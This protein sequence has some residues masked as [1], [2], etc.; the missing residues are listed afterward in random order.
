[1]P[2]TPVLC[3]VVAVSQ[4]LLVVVPEPLTKPDVPVPFTYPALNEFT[5]PTP[6]L[7]YP[8]NPAVLPLLLITDAKL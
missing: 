6:L 5:I 3:P 4:K 1:V 8:T 2:I 7:I